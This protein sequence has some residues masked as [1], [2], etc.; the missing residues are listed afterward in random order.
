MRMPITLTTLDDP[1][2]EE[3]RGSC[4]GP[5]DGLLSIA[6][7][8]A[9]AVRER[10][11]AAD[12]IG[13]TGLVAPAMLATATPSRL[14][15]VPTGF[16]SSYLEM[17][18]DLKIRAEIG[19]WVNALAH[20]ADNPRRLAAI[21]PALHLLM[22][23]PD[24]HGKPFARTARMMLYFEALFCR[25]AYPSS[26][27]KTDLE[28][29]ARELRGTVPPLRAAIDEIVAY[30]LPLTQRG[31]WLVS[32]P[33]LMLVA[34]RLSQ[35]EYHEEALWQAYG[36]FRARD[37][38]QRAWSSWQDLDLTEA[39]LDFVS[40]LIRYQTA[41]GQHLRGTG[42]TSYLR[43]AGALEAMYPNVFHGGIVRTAVLLMG[44][45]EQARSHR[46]P[47]T[48]QGTLLNSGRLRLNQGVSWNWDRADWFKLV[49]EDLP[50]LTAAHPELIAMREPLLGLAGHVFRDQDDY[51]NRLRETLGLDHDHPAIDAVVQLT[52]RTPRRELIELFANADRSAGLPS[53]TTRTWAFSTEFELPEAQT[54]TLRLFVERHFDELVRN[55]IATLSAPGP[56]PPKLEDVAVFSFRRKQTTELKDVLRRYLMAIHES[57]SVEGFRRFFLL[58]PI[59]VAHFLDD[60]KVEYV[61]EIMLRDEFAPEEL[62]HHC[63]EKHDR[64]ANEAARQYASQSARLASSSSTTGSAPAGL[65]DRR[66]PNIPTGPP[67]PSQ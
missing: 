52:Q 53:T 1:V 22:A 25:Q 57:L 17:P 55:P 21:S 8:E 39:L 14:G 2:I 26:G 62:L 28:H 7:R 27:W 23:R 51:R 31:Q 3:L 5:L 15:Y 24:V 16:E 60:Q 9:P 11:R 40:L 38:L 18:L 41:A 65:A 4:A 37:E 59:Q 34:V 29:E 54:R 49:P 63:I 47:A 13:S 42:D 43:E 66:A 6:V 56:V 46:L 20:A 33:L 12:R 35:C 19:R 48:S 67:E 61:I 45:L 58:K 10:D 32:L 30:R 44:V 64:H 36:S 50:A